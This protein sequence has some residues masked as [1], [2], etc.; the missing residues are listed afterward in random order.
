M[1]CHSCNDHCIKKGKQKSGAQKYYCKRCGRYQQAAYTRNAWVPGMDKRIA[2]LLKEACGIRSIGRLLDISPVTVIKRI[3]AIAGKI[4]KPVI[5]LKKEY[6]VDELKTYVGKKSRERWVT[7][8]IK[9]VVDFRTGRRT[10][11]NLGYVIDTLILANARKIYTDRLDIYR[12][13]IPEEIH[14]KRK[15][16]INHI[17]RKNLSLRNHLKRLSRKTICFSKSDLML[18][19]CL[20]IYFWG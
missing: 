19:S 4:S 6:E 9:Q 20:K 18:E 12:H 1:K 16:N 5:S 14:R 2:R 3:K 10:K 17:E 8:A 7:Y 13:L 11:K 15:Y